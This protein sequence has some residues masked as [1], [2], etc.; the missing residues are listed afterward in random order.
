MKSLREELYELDK[1][2]G[3]IQHK[4]CSMKDNKKYRKI[5]KAGKDLPD[6]IIKG[7]VN[8]NYFEVIISDLN[9]EELDRLIKFRKVVYLREIRGAVNFFVVIGVI[10]LILSFVI[11]MA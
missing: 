6:N 8:D 4:P 11:M 10:V 3:L 2:M 1:E 9:E 7:K 5:Q